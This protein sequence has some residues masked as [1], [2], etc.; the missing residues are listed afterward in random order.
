MRFCDVCLEASQEFHAA[1]F[2][3]IGQGLLERRLFELGEWYLS[4][5]VG[6]VPGE[7]TLAS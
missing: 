2:Q 3:E 5:A 1:L 6:K 7:G 4:H